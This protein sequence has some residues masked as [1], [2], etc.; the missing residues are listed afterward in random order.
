M[1]WRAKRSTDVSVGTHK[2][3]RWVVVAD[4]EVRG[5]AGVHE[6]AGAGLGGTADL[7]G[8]LP[9]D[10]GEVAE[11]VEV[12]QVDVIRVKRSRVVA[13]LSIVHVVRDHDAD[14]VGRVTRSNVL[15]VTATIS[16]TGE[17][18]N[19]SYLYSRLPSFG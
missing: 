7:L 13:E 14:L 11:V 18:R 4:S 1:N 10:L 5:E 15:A 19:V 12:G 2:V 3:S 9:H 6:T 17:K 8:A 16:R